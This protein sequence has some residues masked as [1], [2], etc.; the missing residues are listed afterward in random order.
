[1]SSAFYSFLNSITN[2]ITSRYEIKSQISSVGLWKI[3]LGVRKTTGKQVAIFIFEKKALDSTLKRERGA[4]RNDTERVYE[5]L[6]KEASHLARLRHPSILEVVEPVTESRSSIA[7]AT[8]PLYGALSHLVKSADNYSSQ[9]EQ[10]FELDELEIQKGLL[11]VGKGLQFL[12]DAKVVHHNL[13]PD[14]V[15]VNSKG[16]WK[17]GGLGFGIF[18]NNTTESSADGYDYNEYIPDQCQI[19]LD[20]A[21][22][23]YVLNNEITQANDI[24]SLGCIAYAVHNKGV[25]LLQTFN[26]RRTYERKI[27]AIETLD[28]SKM[29]PHLQGVIR[30]LLA[31]QPSQR[32]TIEEFQKSKYFDNLLVSTMKFMESFPEKTREEK[33]QFMKGLSRVLSQF[34]NRILKRKILPSLIEELKDHQLLPYT[35]PNILL[36]TQELTQEEFCSLVLPSLKP[37]FLIRDPPQ[38]MIV[39]LEKL[40]V[41]QQKTPREVFRDDVMPLLYACLESPAPSVQEKALRIVPSLCE[42]LDYT[43]IKSSLFPRVQALFVQTTILSVKVSTLIC[44]H[45]MIKTIDKFTMQEKL[46]PM[47][48]NIKTK[49]PAVMLATL[50]VYD[51]MGNHL[52]KEIVATEILPQLW[53]MSFG[54][55]LNVDQFKKFMKTIRE[56]TTRVEE[57]HTRHLQEVKSLEDQTQSVSA[58]SALANNINHTVG[59]ETVSFESL[60]Q[61]KALQPVQ[62]LHS[63]QQIQ[64]VQPVKE[65][66]DDI[67]GA[68]QTNGNSNGTGLGI[69]PTPVAPTSSVFSGNSGWSSNNNQSGSKASQFIAT[70]ASNHRPSSVP[71]PAPLLAPSAPTSRPTPASSNN[72]WTMAPPPSNRAP[73]NI[74]ML[75][76]PSSYNTSQTTVPPLSS[77]AN[78]SIKQPSGGSN[79]A[80]LQSLVSTGS[81]SMMPLIASSPVP[82]QSNTSGMGLLQPM[83]SRPVQSNISVSNNGSIGHKL[84]N[85]NAFD[86]LG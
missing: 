84:N 44:F 61:G 51:E 12:S 80:A 9:S 58:N 42:S 67:F 6:K 72:S 74:P 2:S 56:L 31:R 10:E 36:I 71:K 63:I 49:E 19:D 52:D 15:F 27:Q 82:Q 75:S 68:F 33:A 76:G 30:R 60:V 24:F 53:K 83:S 64:P 17:I 47:L 25:S 45:A 40:D 85:L 21:A 78:L 77:I 3:Y 39:L 66:N 38:N 55:L 29:P 35:V 5:L 79:Y 1:M 18:L 22:P 26:N 11:Q 34:P 43:T 14:A 8:E 81:G 73:Q 70:T 41:F 16:D 54:P 48:K 65:N 13:T 86:P 7:F 4:S 23:E 59:D 57:S 50:A 28:F 20:Y 62:Q 46:V 69:T 32:L 37:V